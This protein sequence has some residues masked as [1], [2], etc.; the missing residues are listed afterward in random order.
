VIFTGRIPEAELVAYYR[1][2][3]VFTMPSTDRSEAFGLVQLEAMACGKPVVST[4]LG[5]GVEYVNRDGETGLL[6]PPRNAA[7][8]AAALNRL[9]G[10]A[11]LRGRLGEA[12]RAWV[13]AGFSVPAMVDKTLAV[14]RQVLG[15]AA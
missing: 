11:A 13:E 1:A 7:A 9:L 4:R 3:D 15:R 8:L 14:Y 12:G 2:C 6:V 10:D 5:N